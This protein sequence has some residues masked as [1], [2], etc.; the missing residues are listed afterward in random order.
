MA[1]CLSVHLL[2][3]PEVVRSGVLRPGPRG[4]KAWALL[5]YL[6]LTESAP[7]R[8]WLAE[9]LFADASDPLNALSWN[10]S[11]LRR[12]LGE[13]TVLTGEPVVLRLPPGARVDVRV[14]TQGSSEE[15]LGLPGLGQDV[16]AGMSFPSCPGFEVWLLSVRRRV[17]GA[18]EGVLREAARG[19]LAAGDGPGAVDLATRLVLANP[20]DEDSQELLIRAFMACGDVAAAR[21]QRD[22]CVTLFRKELGVDPGPAVLG[23]A[24]APTPRAFPDRRATPAMTRARLEAG[25]SALDAGVVDTALD[26][27]RQAVA[28]ARETDD[29][30]LQ[31]RASVALGQAL[32]HAVRGH[33]GEGAGVLLEA[34]ALAE[35]LGAPELAVSAHRE[36]AYVELLRGRYDRAERWLGSAL[37]LAGD[38]TAERAWVLAVRGVADSDVG[39]HQDAFEALD[40]ALELAADCGLPQVEAWADT[41]AGRTHLLRGELTEARARLER[42]LGRARA[43]G[44]TAFVPLPEVLLG[45][46]DQ[47]EGAEASAQSAYEHAH[48][49]ALQFGDPC[50]E[51]LAAR[52][53]GRVAAA[54]D[55]TE[56]ARKWLL[57]AR[58]R[59]VRLP[60]AHLWIE[61]YCL[62]ALCDLSLD[63]RWDDAS[64]YI[65]DLEALA[66]RTGMREFVA[67]A[68]AHRSRLDDSEAASAAAS[69]LAAEVDNPSLSSRG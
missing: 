19:R 58:T 9:L 3:S 27:L 14:V 55:D 15:A 2:G 63:H 20:W 12:L 22:A 23:A 43:A 28:E 34:V 47:L 66:T 17:A 11:Q 48:A 13:D 61:A 40:Q 59:C 5:T 1:G 46:V 45:E 4:H 6:T 56:T 31:V 65:D 16:L 33:D 24:D 30:R 38:D 54:H 29:R 25:L 32:V 52:G 42:G 37:E 53:L 64:R 10:L 69:V 51:G 57:E 35:E 62:D 44:W 26:L 8:P 39:R 68:Y 18:T 36:L 21:T 67:R 50:W 41:F 49:M 60:D 7:S